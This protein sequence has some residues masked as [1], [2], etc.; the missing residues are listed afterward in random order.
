[1]HRKNGQTILRKFRTEE[2]NSL[3]KK[4]ILGSYECVHRIS[5]ISETRAGRSNAGRR[6][7][8]APERKTI[9]LE[10]FIHID[11]GSG[12]FV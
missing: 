7:R 4:E 11:W 1:M 10:D 6:L 3:W 12:I 9:T 5:S 8:S 2:G